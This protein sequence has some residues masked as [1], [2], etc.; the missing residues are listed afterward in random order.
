MTNNKATS[1]Q[2]FIDALGY[3]EETTEGT[4]P[5]A[6]PTFANVGPSSSL[7]IKKN[8]SLIEIGQ[9]G[10]EDLIAIAQG[11]RKYEFTIKTTLANSTFIKYGIIAA[12]YATPT[13]TVSK[14]LSFA[15]SYYLNGTKNYVLMKGCRCKQ[16]T[17]DIAVGKPHMASLDFEAM[18]ITVPFTTANA[19]LTTPTFATLPT[20]PVWDYTSGGA[21]PVSVGGTGVDCKKISITINRNT[22]PEYVL[23]S[24][25]P[26]STLP[27]GRRIAGSM[28]ILHTLTTLDTEV[29][30]T[31]PV[32]RQLQSC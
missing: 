4:T 12:N 21:T 13:G 3:V 11:L 23:G 32:V 26:F 9:L 16:I 27:H 30:T 28:D 15:F 2:L 10:A 18:A 7:S 25:A 1:N 31:T 29:E 22:N 17:L 20:G 5:T 24:A 14:T 8:N 19:G 6:S